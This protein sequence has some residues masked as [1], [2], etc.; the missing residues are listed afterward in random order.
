MPLI[1]LSTGHAIAVIRGEGD[2]WQASAHLAGAPTAC[3]AVDPLR[4]EVAYAALHLGDLYR[5]ADA[6]QSWQ[7]PAIDWP[8]GY[9]PA[10]AS[11]GAGWL[12]LEVIGV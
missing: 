10:E 6:C 11:A 4:P 2:H 12:A 8:D 9:N 1:Y 3:V 7:P 5:S